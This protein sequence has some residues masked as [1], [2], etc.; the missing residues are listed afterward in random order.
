[1]VRVSWKCR[2]EV[3]PALGGLALCWRDNG[4]CD[5]LVRRRGF[6]QRHGQRDGRRLCVVFADRIMACGYA[7]ELNRGRWRLLGLLLILVIGYLVHRPL[8]RRNRSSLFPVAVKVTGIPSAMSRNRVRPRIAPQRQG[9]Y[10]LAGGGGGSRERPST[11]RNR[12]ANIP[13][14]QRPPA[15]LIFTKRPNGGPMAR[16]PSLR[17]TAGDSGG[18]LLASP[19]QWPIA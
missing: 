6:V 4:E 13:P 12:K 11:G 2:V 18:H 17:P 3:L 16:R 8:R 7:F 5:C 10:G 1:M 9:T 14:R 19:P 15:V